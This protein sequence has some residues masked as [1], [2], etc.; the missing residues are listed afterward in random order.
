MAT[1]VAPAAANTVAE[2]APQVIR[3]HTL[4]TVSL[5]PRSSQARRQD[6]RLL[7][8]HRLEQRKTEGICCGQGVKPNG[9]T[10]GDTEGQKQGSNGDFCHRDSEGF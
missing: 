6:S 9:D 8:D 7:P 3:P 1:S 4:A 5:D 10:E 2:A